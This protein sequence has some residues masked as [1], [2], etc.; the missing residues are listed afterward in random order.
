M[1]DKKDLVLEW[2]NSNTFLNDGSG[3]LTKAGTVIRIDN[4]LLFLKYYSDDQLL[5]LKQ[6]IIDSIDYE[7]R[8]RKDSTF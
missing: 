6:I 7:L 1:Q 8:I 2:L 4:N 3:N 5:K